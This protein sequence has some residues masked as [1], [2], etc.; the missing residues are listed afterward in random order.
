[1]NLVMIGTFKEAATAEEAKNFID[2]LTAQVVSEPALE[3]ERIEVDRHR[4]RFSDA[5]LN[6]MQARSVNTLS[7]LDLEELRYDAHVEQ[8][9]RD[10]VVT[11]DESEVAV[12]LKILVEKGARVEVYSAHDYPDTGHGR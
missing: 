4:R 1:M 10:V 6:L 9:D 7:P 3:T 2:E 8:K 12:F 5:V 11:T